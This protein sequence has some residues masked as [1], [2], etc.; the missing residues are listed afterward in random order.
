MD[1]ELLDA[2]RDAL[3]Y[4]YAPYS[5]FPVAAALRG[6]NGKIYTGVNVENASYPEGVCAETSAISAMVMDGE[7]SI[8]EIAVAGKGDDILTP[9]GG[10]RQRLREF[11]RAEVAVHACGPEG[12]RQ[13]FVL[14][15]L[16]PNA[17]T[18]EHLK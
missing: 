2:V 3:A 16:L 11:A 12:W 17:F 14:G 8:V 7:R 15:D 10:C 1:A 5:G 9:C 6:A 18:P 13:S 4:A